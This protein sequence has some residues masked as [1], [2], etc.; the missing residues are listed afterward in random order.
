[1]LKRLLVLF[2]LS[3]IATLCGCMRPAV[4]HRSESKQL[5]LEVLQTHIAVPNGANQSVFLRIFSD[6]SVEFHPER[7]Q[8]VKKDRI[9]RGQIS[10][11]ELD[12]TIRVLSRE[13]V[14]ELPGIFESSFWI[15]DFTVPR[16][17]QSQKIRVVN[18]SR[19]MAQKNNKPYP[20]A[21][22]RLVCIAWAVRKNLQL[23]WPNLT[24]DCRD[25][26]QKK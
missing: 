8:D 22:V 2:G 5:L 3:A 24:D 16:D 25:F 15:L 4:E 18:F 10:Q 23:E 9:S 20:E 13:D 26:A 12:A 14:A 6:R 7:N 17:T 21:L 1:M 11:E 19:A